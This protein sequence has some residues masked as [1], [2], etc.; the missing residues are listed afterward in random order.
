MTSAKKTTAARYGIFMSAR[1][2]QDGEDYMDLS[3]MLDQRATDG[4]INRV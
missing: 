3:A 2:R 4:D 1:N